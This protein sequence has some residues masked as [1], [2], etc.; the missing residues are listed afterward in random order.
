M[1][2]S[3]EKQ[4]SSITQEDLSGNDVT[5]I[6]TIRDVDQ[7]H[8]DDTFKFME[9][10][11]KDVPEATTADEKRLYRK[12]IRR[13]FPI[14]FIIS[15]LMFADKNAIGFS[16]LLGMWTDI[17]GFDLAKYNDCNS[18]FYAGYLI[19]QLPGHY[20]FQKANPRYFMA[21]NLLVWVILMLCQ[22]SCTKASQIL[23]IRFFLGITESVITPALEH[24]MAIYFTPSEVGV[25]N[26]LFWISVVAV[27]LPTGFI[28]YGCHY[29]TSIRPWK[30]YWI[31]HGA[32]TIVLTIWVVLDYP[33]SPSTYKAFSVKERVWIIRRI[34]RETRSS[35]TEKKLKKYQVWEALKDPVTWLFALYAATSMLAN[36]MNYQQQVIST[37]LGV[38]TLNS[39]LI[40]VAQAGYSTVAFI[41][42]SW[43]MTRWKNGLCY[44]SVLYNIPAIVG[45]VLAIA[46]P[47][48]NKIGIL[49]GCIIVHTDG[50]GYILG[51]AWSQTSAAGYTKR[52]MRTALFMIGYGV[53]N[54]LAPQMW[55]KGGNRYYAA[56]GVQLGISWVGS[57]LI[58]LLIRLILVKRN[59][60]RLAELKY[61]SEGHVI[62]QK[63]NYIDDS[64]Q[65][66]DTDVTMLDLTDME[67]RQ[68][69]YPL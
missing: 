40:T 65:K 52:L 53:A 22:I 36:N 39:N 13:V 11:D 62:A 43:L 15:Y 3:A 14:L 57:S 63:A 54:V 8:M 2:S 45:G 18:L 38:S 66:Q 59:K 28:S 4:E 46:L 51:L 16:K 68:F 61:D 60:Q 26:P 50:F 7:N 44:L 55:T 34:K 17:E 27:G 69:I 35:I 64:E 47:W 33:T 10:N 19:G 30:L 5:P 24:C 31:I 9:E 67:N 58:L 1:S 48:S 41:I 20:I 25:L 49:A 42:G 37:S 56:W 6:V 12:S 32:L 23:A 29:A 21:T